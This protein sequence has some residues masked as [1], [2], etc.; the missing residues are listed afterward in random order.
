MGYDRKRAIALKAADAK[1]EI[2]AAL[3]LVLRVMSPA[4]IEQVQKIFDAAVVNPVI[5]KEANEVYSK[6]VTAQ[7]G[8]QVMRNEKMA[9]RAF[10]MGRTMIPMPEKDKRVRLDFEKLLSV[11]ALKPKTDNADEAS[12]LV[13]IRNTLKEKGVYLRFILPNV[14]RENSALFG[15]W[16]KDPRKFEMWLSLGEDGGEIPAK[17]GV[18]TREAII[19][20]SLL[21]ANYYTRV[22]QGPIQRKLNETVKHLESKLS[23]GE[24]L[25]ME[26]I[27]IRNDTN[28]A[29][30]GI[31]DF[32]GGA[33]FPDMTIW[34][35]PHGL[36]TQALTQN[37]GGNVKDSAKSLVYAAISVEVA[38]KVLKT[39]IAD[40]TTG[41]ARAVKI[42]T[43]AKVAGE[44][45]EM[46]LVLR[47]L[48]GGMIRLAAGEAAAETAGSGVVKK[49][50]KD[51]SPAAY[52]DTNYAGRAAFEKTANQAAVTGGTGG[53]A[54]GGSAMNR[55]SIDLQRR[56]TGWHTEMTQGLEQAYKAKGRTWVTIDEL[57]EIGKKA[58]AIWGNP[59][60]FL[61]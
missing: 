56:I 48:V 20:N 4:Q 29:V 49:V 38:S 6:S 19:G 54:A 39:F 52:Y 1:K 36:L 13:T 18:L 24:L 30:K 37:V 5:Y 11:D 50:V 43:V 15:T 34:K 8:N 9:N 27:K 53:G 40:T 12:Y 28:F 21:G 25:H 26:W 41:A 10:Q 47:A 31:S 3:P 46:F 35:Q 45:A 16:M 51:K 55:Y 17:D 42:L 23:D 44:I 60:G 7:I 22:Y 61:P 57:E 58:D 2:G 32:L 33:N 14:S 59:L